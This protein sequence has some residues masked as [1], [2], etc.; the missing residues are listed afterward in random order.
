VLE[1]AERCF[2]AS[3]QKNTELLAAEP[4]RVAF[5]LNVTDRLPLTTCSRSCRS[6]GAPNEHRT[7]PA[8]R[9]IRF[10]N[11]RD[12]HWA[13]VSN[14]C[15]P[16]KRT[17]PGDPEWQTYRNASRVIL[18]AARSAMIGGVELPPNGK[19]E[20]P[21]R[22]STTHPRRLWRGPR[23]CSLPVGEQDEAEQWR[24]ASPDRLISDRMS[25]MS[26]RPLPEDKR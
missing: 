21:E 20:A 8:A 17:N 23:R 14:A 10:G 9:L 1:T 6:A 15:S 18:S 26:R 11:C 3:P 19:G 4:K 22:S 5:I 24:S 13:A 16:S 7:H 25:R 12:V 2:V